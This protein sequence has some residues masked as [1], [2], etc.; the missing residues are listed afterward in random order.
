MQDTGYNRKWRNYIAVAGYVMWAKKDDPLMSLQWICD[1]VL[2][3]FL[4][5]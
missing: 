4:R 2:E 3:N 1:M 5:Y